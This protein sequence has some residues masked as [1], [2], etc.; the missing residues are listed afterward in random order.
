[1]GDFVHKYSQ[2]SLFLFLVVFFLLLILYFPG[3]N[4]MLTDDGLSG[5]W[6]IEK[7]GWNGYVHNFGCD[8]FYYFHYAILFF[9]Y[10]I[11]GFHG[12]KWLSVYC[13]MQ[14][15]NSMLVFLF[16]KKILSHINTS[17]TG[18]YTA[19]VI[20]IWFALQPY[21]T[22]NILWASTSHYAISLMIL[23]LVCNFITQ[24][25]KIT[26]RKII[27]LSHVLF[28]LSLIT[29]EISFIFPIV[30]A[31]C[32]I[33]MYLLKIK[34]ISPFQYFT[35]YILPQIG[36]VATYMICYKWQYH[37]W[38][39]HDRLGRDAQ[40]PWSHYIQ[41][42]AQRLTMQISNLHYTSH[43]IRHK[44]YSLSAQYA[45]Y[46]ILITFMAIS[47]LIYMKKNKKIIWLCLWLI[48]M[49]IIFSL[50]FL[51]HY[52]MYIIKYENIRY[53][54]F[55]SIFFFALVALLLSGKNKTLNAIS[56][57]CSLFFF[58]FF[59]RLAAKDRA[60]AGKTQN[61][62]LL[63]MPSVTNHKQY[64][65]N[66]P[67]YAKDVYIF[68]Y[69]TRLD[70]ACEVF[71]KDIETKN[72]IQIC[73]YM[74]RGDID[75]IKVDKINDST[76]KLYNHTA[77]SWWIIDGLGALNYETEDYIFEKDEWNGYLLKFKNRLA[78][79]NGVWFFNKNK[80]ENLNQ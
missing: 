15:M 29:L 34:T 41:T 72:V 40:V 59:V 45:P 53:L 56:I 80:F 76:Y 51:R 30:W 75:S 60:V 4:G 49:Y 8:R 1:M 44:M 39:P 78:L 9:L 26:K 10:K 37:F 74:S 2:R 73:G 48:C 25:D 71:R 61:D 42:L 22:E 69:R 32:L 47:F 7:E 55:S 16:F 63:S 23:L 6:E 33:L 79:H 58:I 17:S 31:S 3:R 65:L 67:A 5:L 77:G 50:P 28:A 57:I 70:I 13:F 38:Y 35:H 46:L 11:C 24:E 54:Y 20:A 64:F 18:T 52:F 36:I 14:A 27:L 62:F 21:M 12:I 19:W 68:R 43:D 66:V